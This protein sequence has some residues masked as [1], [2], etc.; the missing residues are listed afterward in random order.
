MSAC[1]TE[2]AWVIVVPNSGYL[3]VIYYLLFIAVELAVA[4]AKVENHDQPGH[5]RAIYAD[6]GLIL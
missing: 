5:F 3:P 4:V 6:I 1:C 2:V